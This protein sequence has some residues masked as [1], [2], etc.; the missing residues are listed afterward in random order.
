MT[1]GIKLYPLNVPHFRSTASL[2][3]ENKI[4]YS[5]HQLP[6]KKEMIVVLRGVN[7]GFTEE[8]IRSELSDYPI[9][10]VHRM[11][12][13]DKVWPL[14]AV[15]LDPSKPQTKNIFELKTLGGLSVKVEAKQK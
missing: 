5:T 15:H 8:N 3:D 13:G 2:L 7:E 1:E 9:V 4:Q 11:K 6:E 10:R 14:V 12:K